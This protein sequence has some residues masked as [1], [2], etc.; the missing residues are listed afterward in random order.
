MPLRFADEDGRRLTTPATPSL[1]PQ[2]T[3]NETGIESAR[4]G[5]CGD[6]RFD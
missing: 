3:K 4:F 2:K 5:A 1:L 6:R